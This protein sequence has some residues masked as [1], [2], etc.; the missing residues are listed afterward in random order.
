MTSLNICV[1]MIPPTYGRKDQGEWDYCLPLAKVWFEF[2]HCGSQRHTCSRVLQ[3]GVRIFLEPP[4]PQCTSMLVV[5]EGAG[6]NW[7]PSSSWKDAKTLWSP[8][9][10]TGA[11]SLLPSV[12]CLTCLVLPQYPCL[13]MAL[14]NWQ[15]LCLHCCSSHAFPA[16]MHQSGP[17]PTQLVETDGCVPVSQNHC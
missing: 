8:W 11:L 1:T 4:P 6:I 16:Q 9:R 14:R 10:L 2:P 12:L 13:C 7:W 3:F 17:A 15:I 5:L